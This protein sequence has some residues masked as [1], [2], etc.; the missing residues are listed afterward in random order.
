[1]DLE[2]VEIAEIA[3][4]DLPTP[5][6]GQPPLP[7]CPPIQDIT[8]WLEKLS[9]MAA[10]LAICFPEKAPQLLVYQASIVRAERNFEGRWWVTYDRC[11]QQKALAIKNL[12][13]S[14][15]NLHLYNEAFT[16]HARATHPQ[17]FILSP[18][19]SYSTLVPA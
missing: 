15:P 2:F 4:D 18:G 16:G 9:L 12:D 17:V 11:H 6:P 10:L 13:W 3:L 5:G 19:G 7:A 8:L 14:V 1:M